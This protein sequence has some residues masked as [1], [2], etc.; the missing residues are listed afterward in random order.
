MRFDVVFLTTDGTEER[1]PL[2][3]ADRY[4]F[5]SV[6]PIRSFPSFRGQRNNTGRWWTATTG[7]HV[8]FESWLERDLLI[9][10]D[11]DP[12][13]TGIASQPFWLLWQQDGREHRHAPDF[14]LRHACGTGAVID[15]RPADRIGSREESVF[16]N[17]A[18]ACSQAGWRFDVLHA[19]DPVRTANLRWLSG[20]RHPRCGRGDLA[21]AAV[22]LA[23]EPV[24]VGELAGALGD[25][26]ATLPVVFHLLWHTR[27]ETNLSVPLTENSQVTVRA[28]AVGT[29]CG[30]QGPVRGATEG[31]GDGRRRSAAG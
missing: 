4:P 30:A 12:T 23:A 15:C 6:P 14:F 16:A 27:L 13:V 24:P 29:A 11:F 1:L 9:G 18:R 31:G 10:F 20:Y 7:S 3:Q 22:G 25:P 28:W 8:G 2:E 21:R 17:T 5:E 26:I 19:P